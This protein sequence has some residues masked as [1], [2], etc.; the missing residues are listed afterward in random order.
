M[1]LF[2]YSYECPVGQKEVHVCEGIGEEKYIAHSTVILQ[3][4]QMGNW[5]LASV[6]LEWHLILH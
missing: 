3:F 4:V 6:L 2:W 1:N 5:L